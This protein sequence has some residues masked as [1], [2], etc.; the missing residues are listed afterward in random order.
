MRLAAS[1]IAWEAA[2]DEAMYEYLASHGI[3]GLEIAP[4]RIFP[5]RPYEQL[6]GA[7]RFRR[8]LQQYHGLQVV[9]MQSVWY[10]RQEKLFG[11]PEER[12]ALRRYTEQAVDFAAALECPNLVFGCPR[13]RVRG[14]AAYEIAVEFF[15]EIGDYAMAHGTVVAIEANPVIYGTD[16]INDTAEAF[17]LVRDADSAGLGV[18][19][20]IGT[21]VENS[22]S[23][24]ALGDAAAIHHVHLSEPYLAVPQE[25]PLHGQLAHFLQEQRYG[26]WVSLEM[27]KPADEGQL[28]EA[29]NYL[30]EVFGDAV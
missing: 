3:T 7:E 24:E 14:D 19:L 15:H 28:Q 10:G 25:R 9:S 17:A 5:E 11:T 30:S 27:K 26:G 13:N 8:D 12:Q 4:T 21:M 2:Q 29:L 22:E 23:V 1:N 6:A 18:N 20:D 16:F